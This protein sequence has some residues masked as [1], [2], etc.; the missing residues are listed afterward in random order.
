M[1][2]SDGA[3]VMVGTDSLSLGS[4]WWF[5]ASHPDTEM[6]FASIRVVNLMLQAP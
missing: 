6:L 3:V 2:R 1:G 4:R 5:R